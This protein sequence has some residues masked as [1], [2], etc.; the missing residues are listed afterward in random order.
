VRGDRPL[1]RVR[2]FADNIGAHYED[3]Y[4]P[5]SP[6]DSLG[7][8]FSGYGTDLSAPLDNPAFVKGESK[9]GRFEND[10][11]VDKLFGAVQLI[12]SHVDGPEGFIN[13]PGGI[14]MQG[15]E[16]YRHFSARIE[17]PAEIWDQGAAHG[18]AARLQHELL[19]RYCDHHG[20]GLLYP[21]EY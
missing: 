15:N 13:A 5:G 12:L 17:D 19:A 4:E 10:Q 14:A 7:I 1:D 20:I 6:Y 9:I 8:M 21:D 16:I 2:R 11:P 18:K 3:T